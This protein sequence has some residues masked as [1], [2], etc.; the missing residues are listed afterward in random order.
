MSANY[1]PL[2]LTE[3]FLNSSELSIFIHTDAFG[4]LYIHRESSL[5]VW[6]KV[7]IRESDGGAREV[8]G[9]GAKGGNLV[10]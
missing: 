10:A 4:V 1:P 3:Q 8:Q 5:G 9:E 6:R 2:V 7:L